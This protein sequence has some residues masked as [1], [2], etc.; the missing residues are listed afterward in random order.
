MTFILFVTFILFGIA[1]SFSTIVG[2]PGGW[3]MLLMAIALELVDSSI[4]LPLQS[5]G[6][7]MIAWGGGAL[8]ASEGIE[9]AASAVGAKL[10][11]A[12]KAGSIAAVIGSIVGAIV[13]SVFAPIVG[14]II[15]TFGGAFLATLVVELRAAKEDQQGAIKAAV[16][17]TFG[18]IMG[19]VGQLICTLLS[20]LLLCIGMY[21]SWFA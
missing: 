5:Y 18:R 14:S 21:Q 1:L 19:S 6:W 13:G 8:V 9:L 17:A 10:G 4:G 3:L 7:A 15:G 20:L 12:S 16:G 11:G 2:I